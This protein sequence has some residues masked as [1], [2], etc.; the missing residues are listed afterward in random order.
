MSKF[1][2]V[3]FSFL[4]LCLNEHR[5]G[6]SGCMAHGYHL[7][8]NFQVGWRS[9]WGMSVLFNKSYLQTTGVLEQQQLCFAVIWKTE[10]RWGWSRN[11]PINR[12]SISNE[13]LSCCLCI[14]SKSVLFGDTSPT[15]TKGF[16][17]LLFA[18]KL[19]ESTAV[20]PDLIWGSTDW[21]HLT[22]NSTV[23]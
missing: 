9:L 7:A 22:A 11:K 8:E 5:L 2:L 21:C 13:Q 17:V 10:E 19:S 20:V 23:T 6:G 14:Y 12:W 4:F 15:L 18:L 3:I 1:E 16:V